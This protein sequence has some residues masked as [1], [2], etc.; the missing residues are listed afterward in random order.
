MRKLFLAMPFLAVAGC[1]PP[2]DTKVI[3]GTVVQTLN[4][5]DRK[6]TA[7]LTRD[8]T[9]YRVYLQGTGQPLAKMIDS[10]QGGTVKMTWDEPAM[11]RVHG[12]CGG[13]VHYIR[14]TGNGYPNPDEQH[15]IGIGFRC[16]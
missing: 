14:G 10:E 2:D 12:I 15:A 11:I 8:G 16:D 13:S 4:S 7:T 9:L 5:A 3:V 6:A 1:A